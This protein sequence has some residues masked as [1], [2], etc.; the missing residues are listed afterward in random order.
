M[1][2][3]VFEQKN[4]CIMF[5]FFSRHTNTNLNNT[6]LVNKKNAW[7]R[8]GLNCFGRRSV[9]YRTPPALFRVRLLTWINVP[10]A[11]TN[12]VNILIFRQLIG[13]W[14][15]VCISSRDYIF[16]HVYVSILQITDI[17]LVF[18]QNCFWIFRTR[19]D[20]GCGDI[21]DNRVIV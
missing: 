4:Y 17:L 8:Y 13:F 19:P 7:Q 20:G 5:S 9:N 18:F 15:V 2:R 3:H 12:G 16:W 6:W 1:S 21:Y 10:T 14:L 11:L